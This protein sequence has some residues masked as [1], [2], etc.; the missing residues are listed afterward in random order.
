MIDKLEE[1]INNNPGLAG[2]PGL[3]DLIEEAYEMGL[4]DGGA[5]SS[6]LSLLVNADSVRDTLEWSYEVNEALDNLSEEDI[7]IFDDLNDELVR[8]IADEI[9]VDFAWESN[10]VSEAI[11]SEVDRASKEIAVEIV[12]QHL[13]K[14]N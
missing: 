6:G 7:T 4:K 13:N 14:K 2:V 12:K 9:D 5:Y 3:D 11:F 8:K 1:L 10:Q